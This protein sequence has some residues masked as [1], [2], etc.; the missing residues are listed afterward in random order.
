MQT[1]F[2][3]PDLGEGLAE[4]EIVKWYVNEGH[5]ISEDDPLVSV[6]TAK[7]LVDVPSPVTG[8][9]KK[10]HVADGTTV[11]THC[12]LADFEVHSEIK[13]PEKMAV[14]Q[15]ADIAET[16]AC[17]HKSH[18]HVPSEDSATV[19]GKMNTTTEVSDDY[20]IIGKNRAPQPEIEPFSSPD[21]RQNVPSQDIPLLH[22][23]SG[24]STTLPATKGL[25]LHST[26]IFDVE[27]IRGSRRTMA[28]A[29]Q[30]SH[31]QIAHVTIFE[32]ANISA[33]FGK[34]DITSNVIRAIC[35]A[36]KEV[37]R[38]NAWLD[39]DKRELKIHQHV[40]LGVAVDTEEGLFV[41]VLHCIDR[42]PQ[43]RIRE[44]LDEVIQEIKNRTASP[45]RFKRA[46]ISLSNFGAIAG[47]YATPMVVPPMVAIVGIGRYFKRQILLETKKGKAKV[48]EHEILPIS[49]SF[50]HRAATGGEGA[51]FLK[52]II[53]ELEE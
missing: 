13:Q 48:H 20:F 49:L 26:D 42:V 17:T 43:Y 28:E 47:R 7:A 44:V 4:A 31:D 6:E 40:N 46:T 1:S 29:M 45:D 11:P 33:W 24:S 51:R 36:T 10:I 39:M 16:E 23:N 8:V 32:E 3:L 37:P 5:Q 52:G 30:S 21:Q 34:K 15:S 12:L 2:Y 53:R 35:E 27:H 41:P 14:T 25:A 38:L 9:V 19:V 18:N 50:D 22:I